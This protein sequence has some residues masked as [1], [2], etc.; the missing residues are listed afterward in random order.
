MSM[1]IARLVEEIATRIAAATQAHYD[2][3]VEGGDTPIE[4]IFYAAIAAHCLHITGLPCGF[5]G[6]GKHFDHIRQD[7]PGALLAGDASS[8]CY[9]TIYSQ[10]VVID[11]PV[12]F[13]ISVSGVDGVAAA[14]LAIECDGHEFHERTKEQAAR[15]RAR[16][17]ALQEAGLTI[18]RFTGSEIYRDPFGCADQVDRWCWQSLPTPPV[19]DA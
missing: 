4:A 3:R 5:G 10:I 14:W 2:R 18:F 13:L 9:V 7:V 19:E 15:D 17:R 8:E 12:D 16:D 1:G 11:W 6:R